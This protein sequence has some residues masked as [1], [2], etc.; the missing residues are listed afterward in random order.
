[1]RWPNSA[2]VPM[3]VKFSPWPAR[4][5]TGVT[6]VSTK[7]VEAHEGVLVGEGS[8]AVAELL[9]GAGFEIHGMNGQRKIPRDASQ[10]D[11][12]ANWRDFPLKDTGYAPN[13]SLRNAR[14]AF[15]SAPAWSAQHH[16][17]VP[18]I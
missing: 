13:S 7:A 3:G 1:M 17:G 14:A 11:S 12:R 10:T 6:M 5:A 8:A 2:I 15:F 9:Q 18:A 4:S 16:A